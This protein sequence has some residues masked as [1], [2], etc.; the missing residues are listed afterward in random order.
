MMARTHNQVWTKHP[1]SRPLLERLWEKVEKSP[2]AEGCWL[3]LGA[4]NNMGYGQ[5]GI[6]G[7]KTVLVHRVSY[8]ALVGPIPEGKV[9]DHLCRTTNCINPDHLEPVVQRENILRGKTVIAAKVAQEFCIRGHPLSGDNL[10]PYALQHGHREC[11]ICLR[12]YQ[13]N[14]WPRE[15]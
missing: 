8:E 10:D 1:V 9:L 15:P 3:W 6:G 4:T 14:H 13:R 11:K 5:I 2:E 7:E 12:A